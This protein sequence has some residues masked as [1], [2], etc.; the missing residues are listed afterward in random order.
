[1]IKIIWNRIATMKKLF[2]IFITIALLVLCVMGSTY[3]E[4]YSDLDSILSELEELTDNDNLNSIDG[5]N[6]I[7]LAKE[8]ISNNQCSDELIER[9]NYFSLEYTRQKIKATINAS[10]NTTYKAFKTE[11]GTFKY[12]DD[13]LWEELFELYL[14]ALEDIE[15]ETTEEGLALVKTNFF[16]RASA[17]SDKETVKREFSEIVTNAVKDADRAI[18]DIVNTSLTKRGLSTT[19]FNYTYQYDYDNEEYFQ[20]LEQL[21]SMGYDSDNA[22]RVLKWH[23]LL[24]N[25]LIELDLH[26]TEESFTPLTESFIADLSGISYNTTDI[27][28]YILD[29]LKDSLIYR[30]ESLIGSNEILSLSYYK[31][32]K[33]NSIYISTKEEIQKADSTEEAQDALSL[34][35]EKIYE[36]AS[37]NDK[38]I[39][40][41]IIISV[42]VI[43]LLFATAILCY[44]KKKK[45]GRSKYKLL[46]E[47]ERER[48]DKATSQ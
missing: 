26:S 1:M 47:E 30:L 9:V 33:I 8:Y 5:Y 39:P 13:L 46:I 48:V 45:A 2:I 34:G 16:N 7:Y 20:K 6:L 12:Y 27:T 11:G 10:V 14:Q 21:I 37:I 32:K 25:K 31:R 42:I 19:E 15:Q 41:T 28:P 38:W 29:S 3:A 4:D 18:L 44:N 36:I 17:I 40:G 35:E 43:L 22:E 24:I 23:E